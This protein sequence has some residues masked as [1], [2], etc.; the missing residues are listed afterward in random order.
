MVLMKELFH[1]GDAIRIMWHGPRLTYNQ[2]VED[3][4]QVPD[5]LVTGATGLIGSALSRSLQQVG[6]LVRHA[7]RTENE[8]FWDPSGHESLDARIAAGVPRVLVHLAAEPITGLWTAAKKQRIRKSRIEGT[9]N[10]ARQLAELPHKPELLITASGVGAYGSRGDEVL[11]DESPIGSGFLAELA[12]DWEQ[13]TQPARDAGIRVVNLRIGIVLASNGGALA[14]MLP[15]FRAGL[16][17]RFGAGDQW[18]SWIALD[19][20]IHAMLH[21]MRD[22]SLAGA[23][24][25][26]SPEPVTNREFTETLARLVHR[27]AIFTVPAWALRLLPGGMGEEM[28]LASTRAVPAKLLASGFEFHHPKL[29]EALGAVLSS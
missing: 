11:T 10:V 13:A 23:V 1:V 17:G 4:P 7:P 20:L 6:A 27:P 25:A 8:F 22:R 26:V 12:H 15:V 9:R 3:T 24:N 28:L 2:G 5:V 14:Q 21:V 18:M 29:Q 19:D 16:A